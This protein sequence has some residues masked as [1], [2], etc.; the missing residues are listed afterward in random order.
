MPDGDD[1]AVP[2]AP[3]A[4]DRPFFAPLVR[5]PADVVPF[6]ADG[7]LPLPDGA[8][9]LADEVLLLADG[10]LLRADP[11][12]ARGLA[13]LFPAL[14]ALL[15]AGDVLL[16]ALDALLRADGAL[17]RADEAARPRAGVA[18]CRADGDPAR[19]RA[20]CWA[21]AGVPRRIDRANDLIRS[22]LRRLEVP[23]T[24][25]LRSCARSSSTRRW[26][27]SLSLMVPFAGR[28]VAVAERLPVPPE[29]LFAAR[30]EPLDPRDRVRA[31]CV[32]P[33][34]LPARWS[35]PLDAALPRRVLACCGMVCSLP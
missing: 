19:G 23:V 1:R 25:R 32:R 28:I 17:L 33:A 10:L 20:A 3:F 5:F 18:L 31:D 4:D 15:R 12:P 2:D 6:R 14:D 21:R 7:A 13:E 34:W 30:D 11:V 26:L 8:L 22:P 35:R 27:R 29:R 9:F 16:P 24:P